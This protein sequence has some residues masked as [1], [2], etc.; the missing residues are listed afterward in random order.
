MK[1]DRRRMDIE[2]ELLRLV[3]ALISD[4]LTPARRAM[5]KGRVRELNA[6][7]DTL[8]SEREAKEAL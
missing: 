4:C 6:E 7:W 8:S 3:A 5:V 1:N 2:Q